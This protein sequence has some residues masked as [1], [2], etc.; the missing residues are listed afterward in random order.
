VQFSAYRSGRDNDVKMKNKKCANLEKGGQR[1][2]SL[3]KEEKDPKLGGGTGSLNLGGNL[4]C[5]KREG[6]LIQE[7][8]KKEGKG[9]RR[10]DMRCRV[11][12]PIPED[13]QR[14]LEMDK[15]N[16]DR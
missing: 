7:K 15:E 9:L 13:V 8:K 16:R 5:R 6:R 2:K 4:T 11:A 3:G 10:G 12:I 1:S 14:R